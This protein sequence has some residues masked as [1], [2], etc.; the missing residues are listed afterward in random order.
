MGCLWSVALA[1]AAHGFRPGPGRLDIN[2]AA[3]KETYYRWRS[4]FRGM[5]A[6]DARRLKD[7]ERENATLK[8]LLAE[9]EPV[10]L[11]RTGKRRMPRDPWS[12]SRDPRSQNRVGRVSAVL[13]RS[14]AAC[15][16]R[17]AFGARIGSGS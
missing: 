16:D 12:L 5:N 17:R 10:S 11:V 4:Q 8:W 14:R 9:A 13:A 6:N 3:R 7:M 1:S 15:S 2:M